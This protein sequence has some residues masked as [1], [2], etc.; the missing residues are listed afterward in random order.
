MVVEPTACLALA[1]PLCAVNALSAFRGGHGDGWKPRPARTAWARRSAWTA[2]KGGP[3][4]PCWPALFTAV[5]RLLASADRPAAGS[6]ARLIWVP[7]KA[8]SLGLT[9]TA[10]ARSP[11]GPDAP[12][13]RNKKTPGFTGG[14]PRWLDAASIRGPFDFQSNALPTELPSRDAHPEVGI[15]RTCRLGDPD[16]T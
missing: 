4:A 12:E 9:G 11:A 6:G 2:A 16:R 15:R 5:G 3:D 13:P 8:V 10:P 7:E 14:F 1:E